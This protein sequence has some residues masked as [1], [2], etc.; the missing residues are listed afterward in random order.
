MAKFGIIVNMDKCVGCHA[1]AIA[2]KEENQVDPGVF[3]LAIRREENIEERFVNYFRMGCMHCEKPACLPVCPMKAIFRGPAG[4]V[5]VDQKKCIGCHMCEKACPYG[6]PV[7]NMTGA[8]S[9]FGDKV[10][11]AERPLETW[12]IHEPG[13]AEHCTLCT[14]RTS[15]GKVPACVEFCGIGA[16][17][18]VDYENSTKETEP[19]I[20]RA[21]AM[22]PAAGTEPKIRY[23]ASHMDVESC[24]ERLH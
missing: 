2:C 12:M 18:F 8:K 15:A 24:R 17:T 20:A 19:L 10:P 14:H 13:K 21:R 9:Y 16:I 5:L 1:C 11:L 6:V 4:E 22:N 23:I 3:Y 7:F